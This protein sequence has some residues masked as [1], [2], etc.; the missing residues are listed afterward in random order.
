MYRNVTIKYRTNRCYRTYRDYKTTKTDKNPG[1][2]NITN[3]ALKTA[4]YIPAAPLTKLFNFIPEAGVTPIQWSESNIIL[5][6]KKGN[7]RDIGNYRPIS[8]LPCM[9]KLFSTII[10]LRI[11]ATLESNQP[12]EQ[13]GF[14]KKYSTI[15]QIH[16]LELI[17]EKCQEQQRPLYNIFIDYQKAF[18]SI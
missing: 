17:I 13:A 2:D 5:I 7:P 4:C 18:D 8:L 6:Y 16:T 15:D 3:D 9:Y 1:S 11:N 12:I 10:N 14:R